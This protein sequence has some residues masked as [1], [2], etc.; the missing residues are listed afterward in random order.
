MKT[1]LIL[2]VAL[3]FIAITINAQSFVKVGGKATDITMSPKDGT[4]YVVNASGNIKKYNSRTKKFTPHGKQSKNAKSVTVDPN[5]SVYITS[6]LDEVYIDVN[7]RWNKIP[8]IKTKE[9]DID[10]NGNIRALDITGKLKKLFQGRWKDQ[11]AANRNSPGFNQVIGRDSKVLYARFKDNSFREFK[12]AKWKNLNGKPLKI[13]IDDKTGKVYAVGRNKGI[14]EWK[15]T[16]NKWVLL[17]NTRKDFKDVAVYNGK[18]W[19][20]GTDKSIYYYDKNIKPQNTESNDYSGTYRVT[21]TK[22]YSNRKSNRHIMTSLDLYGTIGV[23]VNVL[24]K[25]GNTKIMPI[26]NKKNR[27]WDISKSNPRRIKDIENKRI[28]WVNQENDNN[29]KWYGSS[30]VDGELVIDMIREFK[31]AGEAANNSLTFDIQSNL[32]YKLLTHDVNFDWCRTKFKIDELV[33]GKEYF[34]PMSHDYGLDGGRIYLY[35]GFKI[36]KT[37]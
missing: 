20:I 37:N 10:K 6:S 2:T 11:T 15:S 12:N 28:N 34:R 25:S 21:I 22:L 8:G 27:V 23:Y 24:T 3:F 13:T 31:I 33:L 7:G 18:I 1:N 29:K 26:D 4:V 16:S 9:V 36:E 19:A 17:K 35:L 5:G 14:Y 30:D 32:S